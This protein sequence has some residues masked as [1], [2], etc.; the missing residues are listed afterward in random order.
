MY[1]IEKDML[2]SI[3]GKIIFNN[4]MLPQAT[5]LGQQHYLGHCKQ[6]PFSALKNCLLEFFML[7]PAFRI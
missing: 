2:T 7:P 5:L 3:Y 6:V 1:T 4:Y